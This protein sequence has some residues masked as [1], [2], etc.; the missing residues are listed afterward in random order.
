MAQR[1]FRN[2]FFATLIA[3]LLAG[4]LSLGVLYGFFDSRINQELQNKALYISRGIEH[5]SDHL[6]Y[7]EGFKESNTRLTFLDED[8]T[9]LFDSEVNVS[10]ME[11]HLERP[12]IR[13]ALKKGSGE[14]K[15][16]SSTLGEKTTYYALRLEDGK[17]LRLSNT[18]RSVFG[19]LMGMLSSF[20]LV[21]LCTAVLSGILA[22]RMSKRI[23]QPINALD[24]ENPLANDV[25]DELAP[26]LLRMAQQKKRIGEH[27][28]KLKNKQ[29]EFTAITNNMSEGLVLLDSNANILSINE[30]ASTFFQISAEECL[31]KHV[32]VLNRSIIVRDAVEKA[33][34]GISAEAL[35]LLNGRCYQLI[36]SPVKAE[37]KISGIVMLIL[38]VTEKENAEKMRREFTANVS[39]ELKTPL[40]S[41]S[42]Y[43][44]IMRNG[45]VRAEDM[46]DFAGRISEETNRLI[47]LVEDILQLSRLDEKEVMYE[48]EELDLFLLAET[49]CGRLKPY[50]ENRGVSLSIQGEAAIIKGVRQILEEM[51]YNLCDNAIKYNCE[52]GKVTVEVAQNNEEVVL[53][54]SD[55]G[56]GIPPEHQSK[57]FER[58]YRVDKSHSKETGGTG[59]G[60]SIVK[61]GALYHDVQIRL[62]SKEGEGT[63]IKLYF[64]KV[65]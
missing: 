61:H 59:L 60:L 23:L 32:L 55:T 49:V 10:A 41:I 6:E 27:L 8:G 15:R 39:H 63:E 38:D 50:A 48:K 12:E 24:L 52:G 13:S 5:A 7:L 28:E 54:V 53:S 51:V 43:A 2:I 44:E 35:L 3:V 17:I 62:N 29:R 22:Y 34:N 56:I 19:V 58:F 33:N 4:G 14:S 16:Y 30:S 45:V 47:T 25:Y 64:P 40:T 21:T 18:Q 11:N 20:A 42:G 57:V 26:L 9:V 65:S 36:V 31:G 46:V 37:K 1:I